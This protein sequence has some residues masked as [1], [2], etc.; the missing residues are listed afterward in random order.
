MKPTKSTADHLPSVPVFQEVLDLNFPVW[1]PS[2]GQGHNIQLLATLGTVLCLMM[3]GIHRG[4]GIRVV[5][6][7]TT[8]GSHDLLIFSSQDWLPSARARQT[9]P[10]FRKLDIWFFYK[11]SSWSLL[12]LP[13][14]CLPCHHHPVYEVKTMPTLAGHATS[15]QLATI[16]Q[17]AV[18]PILCGLHQ[19]CKSSGDLSSHPIQRSLM[20]TK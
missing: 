15:S 18:I 2:W 13:I 12:P 9:T 1:W 16:T 4:E 6:L 7:P 3:A 20:S 11:I 17:F 19:M 10:A 8:R 14:C 5:L